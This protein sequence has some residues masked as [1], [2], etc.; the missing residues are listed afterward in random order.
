MA[1]LRPAQTKSYMNTHNDITNTAGASALLC[2]R[3]APVLLDLFCCGGIA[4]DGY[5]QAGFHVIGIDKE[6]HPNNPHEFYQMDWKEGLQKFGPLADAI[7]ASPPCQ[8]NSRTRTLHSTEYENPLPEVRQELLKLGKPYII[9]NV[10]GAEMDN[11]IILDGPM[12]GLRVIRKRKFESNLLLMM[13][14]KG[15]KRGSVGAKNCTRKDFNG[16]YIVGGHQM[17]TIEEWK[18]A[19]GV[20][21]SR[22]ISREELA[23]AI[24]PSYTFFLGEQL[25][26]TLHGT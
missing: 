16:Y 18:G 5:K 26:R 22:N 10:L 2:S 13:P 3:A 14:G 9:E 20:P 24:P 1:H 15:L 7:H 8:E 6:A 23:E 12:F 4:G 11:A 21:L 19:M 25:R 17:G